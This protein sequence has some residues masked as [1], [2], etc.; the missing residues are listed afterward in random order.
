MQPAQ[1]GQRV[2]ISPKA[3]CRITLRGS[4]GQR[5]A[6]AAISQAGGGRVLA[7]EQIDPQ[8]WFMD[9]MAELEGDFEIVA[10]VMDDRHGG[11]T[12][13]AYPI[14]V[15]VD[16]TTWQMPEPT[17][18]LAAV[19]LAEVYTRNGERRMKLSNEGFTFGIDAYVRARNLG[20]V[21]VP[22]RN[23]PGVPLPGNGPVPH[24]DGRG[25]GRPAPVP[26]QLLGSGSGVLIAPDIIVTNAHVIEDGQRFEIGR[27]RDVA[28]PLAVDV[29]HDLALLRC[30]THG[31]PLPLRIGSPLFLGEDVMAAGFPLIDVLGA[32][33]K[34]TTGNVSG[35]TGGGGDVSRFQ[36]SAPIGSG[37]S[38][39]AI[40][41]ECGNLV[42][43]TSA[44]LAHQNMRE[45]GSISENVN[46]GIRAALVFEMAAAAG[47][48]LPP[49]PI[50][51]DN[52]R[53]N[54]VA[55]ARN[56]VVSILVHA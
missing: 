47:A 3:D 30:T 29:Q 17:E 52:L 10:Y 6:I 37:S 51:T 24:P 14:A 12:N 55:R 19:I 39:G 2:P 43:I 56:A 1:P 22:F 44:S 36:F 31:S 42:G 8:H 5:I 32:D 18:Q 15:E 7:F 16:G 13:H 28:V 21:E 25:S 45:R 27:A 54:V 11:F 38:G 49:L 20:P 34:V 9:G 46:F 48:D 50:A 53:R 26:G 23:T 33:L 35:L 41:D 40:I 4:E